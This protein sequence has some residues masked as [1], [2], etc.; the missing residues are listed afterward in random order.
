[1]VETKTPVAATSNTRA[2]QTNE[3]RRRRS[4]DYNGFFLRLGIDDYFKNPDYVFRW[5]NDDRGK[6]EDRTTRD[7]W[8]FVTDDRLVNGSRENGVDTRVRRQVGSRSDGMPMYAY[9][10]RKLKSYQD[11]DEARKSDARRARKEDMVLTQDTA[12]SGGVSADKAHTYIPAE[13]NASINVTRA[14][15]RRA[16]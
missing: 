1:M 15:I 16:R 12:A 2:E 6:L 13:V 4:D 3:Q 11:E 9:L 5:F 10:C 8:D 7:D 14:N